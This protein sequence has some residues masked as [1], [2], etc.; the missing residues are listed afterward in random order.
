[1]NI[2]YLDTFSGIS[3]DMMLGLLVDLGVDL[4]LIEAELAKLSV[5]GYK[6][7]Q[8]PEKRHSIGGTRVEVICEDKQPARTW[9]EIDA[10]LAK[11]SLAEP[12]RNR[13]RNIFRSLGEAEAKVHQVALNEVHF[14]EVGAVDAIVD[15]VGSAIGLYL[16]GVEKI[17]CTPLPLSSGMI[18]GSHGAMPLP[19]PAT[20][21]IL[22]GKPVRNADCDRELVTPTGAA[23]AVEIA[24]FGD[25]PEMTIERIGYGVGGWDLDDRPNLLRGI[26]GTENTADGFEQDTVTVIETHIDDSSPEW[27]GALTE[28]LLSAGALD[29]GLTALQMK[30]NRPG[31]GLTV[32]AQPQQAKPLA[33]MILREST[34][35]GVRMH[36][37][38]RMKLRREPATVQTAFGEAA[39]KLIYEGKTLLRITPEHDSCQALATASTRPLP[40]IYRAITTA[41]NRQFGLED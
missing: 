18:R 40:E 28:R 31:T 16:L 35:I 34:A 12:V 26:I 11:S 15:I 29:V 30:K 10:M 37:T 33:Q 39:V 27:L 7:E 36:E 17:I 19:A 24:C 20:L 2:L 9:S 1:M 22:Q 41:A 8:R 21:Q 3:G 25:M 4:N 14:H 38:R 13:A 32:M 23:I 6:L 5:S